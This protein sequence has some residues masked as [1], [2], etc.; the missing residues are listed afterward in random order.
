MGQS[1]EEPRLDLGVISPPVPRGPVGSRALCLIPRGVPWGALGSPKP[2]PEASLHPSFPARRGS[3]WS[4]ASGFVARWFCKGR[5][6]SV[7]R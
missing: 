2:E 4:P 7:D 3:L 5:A 1:V 6:V